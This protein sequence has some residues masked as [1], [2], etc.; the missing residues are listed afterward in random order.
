MELNKK[1]ISLIIN[2]INE[3]FS[4]RQQPQNTQPKHSIQKY[5]KELITHDDLQSDRM[6]QFDNK[7]NNSLL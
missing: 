6:S 7:L 2:Y 5:E 3:N 4:Q 1:Y